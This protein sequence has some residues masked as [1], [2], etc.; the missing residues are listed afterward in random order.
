[1]VH[2]Q[3]PRLGGAGAWLATGGAFLQFAVQS[4]DGVV[5]L[6]HRSF[7]VGDL[8]VLGGQAG[9]QRR[10]DARLGLWRRRVLGQGVPG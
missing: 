10:N 5:T 8:G 1:V 7:E 3:R 6:A 4:G 9:P 2:P